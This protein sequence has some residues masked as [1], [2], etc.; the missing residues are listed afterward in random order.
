ME[1]FVWIAVLAVFFAQLAIV[2]VIIQRYKRKTSGLSGEKTVKAERILS[3]TAKTGGKYFFEKEEKTAPLFGFYAG[4][5]QF[6]ISMFSS[7]AV[8]CG[9]DELSDLMDSIDPLKGPFF[10]VITDE[11]LSKT[12]QFQSDIPG[13]I[14][15]SVSDGYPGSGHL[16]VLHFAGD[17][18]HFML[19]YLQGADVVNKYSLRQGEL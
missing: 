1:A 7:D 14:E 19:D 4:I 6:N 13:T 2:A 15:V 16:G 9:L 5:K 12:L 18:K 8:L 3:G 11:R 17:M 10:M